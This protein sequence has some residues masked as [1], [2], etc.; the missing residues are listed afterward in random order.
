MVWQ[1]SAES[2]PNV[3]AH[4]LSLRLANSPAFIGQP[5]RWRLFPLSCLLIAA[6]METFWEG[7]PFSSAREKATST[8]PPL[9]WPEL[10]T[11]A[12]SCGHCVLLGWNRRAEVDAG[13]AARDRP[14]AQRAAGE[15]VT[16]HWLD[17][18]HTRRSRSQMGGKQKGRRLCLSRETIANRLPACWTKICAR[19]VSSLCSSA[20]L[21]IWRK[22]TSLA[23]H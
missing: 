11:C 7:I 9:H 5:A 12:P 6:L 8:T 4:C 2:W 16:L 3:R 17:L 21:I 20:K 18:G 19:L 10:R 1:A 15:S 22:K 14:G 23:T 13:G